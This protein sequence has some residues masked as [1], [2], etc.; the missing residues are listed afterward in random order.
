[1]LR[2]LRRS[3]RELGMST[4]IPPRVVIMSGPI[5][6]LFGMR[7][8]VQGVVAR[9]RVGMMA[10]VIIIVAERSEGEDRRR[11]IDTIR[12]SRSGEITIVKRS[13]AM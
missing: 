3:M 1:M 8:R 2:L 11:R 13:V 6:R 10:M 4:I 9:K 7:W 12:T 5:R